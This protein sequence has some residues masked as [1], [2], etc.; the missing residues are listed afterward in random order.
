MAQ[1]R[2]SALL[3]NGRRPRTI[4]AA[5]VDSARAEVGWMRRGC[6]AASGL[7]PLALIE[8]L[9]VAAALLAIGSSLEAR[10]AAK[11]PIGAFWG[12]A[13]LPRPVYLRLWLPRL[14]AASGWRQPRSVVSIDV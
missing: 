11:L 8:M 6:F 1:S 2:K 5:P 9:I 13:A 12:W 4:D 3:G 7:P 10:P 14:T